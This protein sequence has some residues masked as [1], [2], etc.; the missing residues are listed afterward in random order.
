MNERA[1]ARS[2]GRHAFRH[3][4]TRAAAGL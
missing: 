2:A 1:P 3:P 4:R